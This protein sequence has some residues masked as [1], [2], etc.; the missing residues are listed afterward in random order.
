MKAINKFL[1]LMLTIVVAFSS[2]SSDDDN[3]TEHTLKNAIC[4]HTHDLGIA[5]A[6][7]QITTPE[8]TARLDD[9]LKDYDYVAPIIGGVMN[10]TKETSIE[11]VGLK[12]GITLQQFTL[13]INGITKNF[14]NLTKDDTE[15]YNDL[16]LEYFRNVFNRMV[17][18]NKLIV[19]ASYTPSSKI[20]E[21]D[22][23]KINFVFKGNF[24]YRK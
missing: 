21:E 18:Q 7:A 20:S 2:C 16:N 17:S 23:L 8:T 19:Q 4:K 10:L 3:R 6:G 24:I 15:L 5:N 14:G 11:I 9:M 1:G 12:E 22:A 13:T